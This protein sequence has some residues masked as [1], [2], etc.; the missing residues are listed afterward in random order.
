[1][2][3]SVGDNPFGP[4]Q[5]GGTLNYELGVNVAEGPR[6]D[7]TKQY[8]PWRY[9]QSN[10][11]GI[12]EYHGNEYL[13]YH[14][15]ALSSWR[16]D[17]F[18]GPGTWTQRSV[19]VDKIVYD[20][21]GKIIPVQQTL[22]GVDPV[23]VNQPFEIVLNIKNSSLKNNILEFKNMD[24]GSGYYYAGIDIKNVESPTT[25]EIHLDSKD[26]KLV[27]T[28]V[29]KRDGV[30]ETLL[31]EANGIHNIYF[32]FKDKIAPKTSIRSLRIFA[33]CPKTHN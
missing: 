16:Q 23:M 25:C 11:G 9:M 14:T 30:S 8:V 15:S 10:H 3:Y 18:K 32:V 1:M 28:F 4:F 22:K 26:G 29:I 31:R 5:Y 13:F 7:S 17:A 19:C 24:L 6:I 27:G 20:K 21:S 33:G 12:V 2:A